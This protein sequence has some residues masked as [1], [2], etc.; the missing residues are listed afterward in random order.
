MMGR[1]QATPLG[2]VPLG[3]LQPPVVTPE[4]GTQRVVRASGEHN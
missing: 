2:L 3:K 4:P 1:T